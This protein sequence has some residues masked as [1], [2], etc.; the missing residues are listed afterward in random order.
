MK[1][2]NCRKSG[3]LKKYCE[4]YQAGIMCGANCKC[5]NCQ[6]FDPAAP[7]PGYDDSANDASVV[8]TSYSASS[9]AAR[10]LVLQIPAAAAMLFPPGFPSSMTAVKPPQIPTISSSSTELAQL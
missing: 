1:G 7:P 3:C 8:A 6:N 5:S 4:C 9:S 2:C 10:G